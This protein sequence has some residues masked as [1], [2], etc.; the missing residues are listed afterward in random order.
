MASSEASESVGSSSTSLETRFNVIESSAS[1]EEK[2]V[3]V[4]VK[5]R[6]YSASSSGASIAVEEVVSVSKK[7]QQTRRPVENAKAELL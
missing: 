5:K 6:R 7:L 3:Q 2:V 1:E 4:R